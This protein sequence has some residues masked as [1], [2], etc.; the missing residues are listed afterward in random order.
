MSNAFFFRPPKIVSASASSTAAGYDPNNVANDYMGLVWKSGTGSSS[1]T[2]TIALD[3]NYPIDTMLLFGCTGALAGW[4]VQIDA[5]LDDG[6]TLAGGS[7]GSQP[8][9]AGATM[10]SHGRGVGYYTGGAINNVT[11]WKLT[12]G[13]LAGAAV[14]IGR[15][16]LG[17]RNALG[18]N[19]GFG[20]GW[21]VRDLGTVDWSPAGTLLRRRA[22]KLRTVGVT[23][24]NT[25]KSEVET[26]ILPFVELSGGQ[27]PIVLVTDPAVDAQRQTR[28]YFGPLI[29]EL[30]TV[31]RMPNAWEWK[32]S[33]VDLVPVPKAS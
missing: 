27:E 1:Q 4:T 16:C 11:K 30:G 6:V 10:P 17:V 28:C 12:F 25:Y 18:R 9:L 24:S 8:F 29:G 5:L 2:L 7:S 32:V 23:F 22:A 14:T 20:G 33:L 3:A 19:F 26:A 21:G 15:V 13:N 31:W